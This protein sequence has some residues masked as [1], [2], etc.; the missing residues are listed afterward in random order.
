MNYVY[1]VI[2]KL[3][4][5]LLFRGLKNKIK[6]SKIDKIFS[7]RQFTYINSIILIKKYINIH[8]IVPLTSTGGVSSNGSYYLQL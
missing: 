8:W 5:Q 2:G 7:N 3:I 6:K 4:M 1:N